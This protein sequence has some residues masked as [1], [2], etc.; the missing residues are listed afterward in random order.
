MSEI[1]TLRTLEVITA[2][3]K[4][5][6][7]RINWDSLYKW[8][9]L[10]IEAKPLIPHGEWLTYL[11]ENFPRVGQRQAYRYIKAVREGKAV[12]EVTVQRSNLTYTSNFE[13]HEPPLQVTY[14]ETKQP[15]TKPADKLLATLM[16]YDT[17]LEPYAADESTIKFD[18]GKEQEDVIKHLLIKLQRILRKLGNPASQLR[19]IGE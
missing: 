5:C 3:A 19:A 4:A 13:H 12:D 18:L 16:K 1:T 8:A 9:E 7:E 17:L 6:Y 14:S 10:M 2:E 11:D 15:E